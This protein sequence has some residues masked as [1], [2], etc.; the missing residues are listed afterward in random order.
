MNVASFSLSFIAVVLAAYVMIAGKAL[1]VPF[2]IALFFWYLINS[3]AKAYSNISPWLPNFVALLLAI[4]SFIGVIWIPVEL[5]SSAIPEVVAAA[6]TYQENLQK[7]IGQAPDFLQ[8]EQYTVTSELLHNLDL[9]TLATGFAQGLTGL[10]GNTI[11]IVIYIIFLLIEQNSFSPKISALFADNGN[12]NRVRKML[13]DIHQ[14]IQTYVW[15]KS[16]MSLV[17]GLLSYGIMKFVGVDFAAFW[18]VVIFFL[19]FIPN[20]G[21]A[22]STIFPAIITLLQFGEFYPFLV[23]V[24]GITSIQFVVGNVLEPKIMG[25]SLNLSPVVILLSLVFWGSIWGFTGM[26]LSV[27]MTV[28]MMIIFAEFPRT[29]PIAVILSKDG[30]ITEAN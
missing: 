10:A 30:S 22:L 1:L 2:V 27:P 8:L 23:V 11:L 9:G 25:N 17:T 21:S 12:E 15:I 26:Y 7:F 5:V 29:K 6:P 20:I 13:S 3:L 28:I 19:N 24:G 14:R 4:A 16:V 18:A